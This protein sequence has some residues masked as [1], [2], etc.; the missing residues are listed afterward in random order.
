MFTGLI[1]DIGEVQAARSG[2]FRIACGYALGQEHLG[3][4]IACDGCC[5]TVTDI[6]AG[7]NGFAT[8][9]HVDVS[10]ETLAH[11][12]LGAWTPGR[13]IN[14]ER[15]LTPSSELGGHI[16]TGHV[17]GVASILGREKDG[18][19][20]RFRL[21]VDDVLAQF[22]AAK[23]SVALNG[24]SFTVNDVDRSQFGINLI[25]H[26]LEVTTWGDLAAGNSVNLEVDLLA[27]YVARITDA[28]S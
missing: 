14:L 21:Q 3:A 1:T 24:V 10:N 18:D 19:S 4:S 7:S 11:T 13:K 25:P 17:D 9:F 26:T 27:R 2:K 15:P 23:G 6:T 5:L 8:V 20:V 12:T 28:R 16:V 22:I